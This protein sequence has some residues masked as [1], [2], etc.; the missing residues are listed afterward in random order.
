MPI[1]VCL[2]ILDFVNENAQIIFLYTSYKPTK[3][4]MCKRT[5]VLIILIVNTKLKNP[6]LSSV[7]VGFAANVNKFVK[8]IPNDIFSPDTFEDSRVG[9]WVS[10]A[11]EAGVGGWGSGCRGL[12]EAGVWGWGSGCLGMGKRVSGDGEAGVWGWGS[13]CL[14][15]GKRVSGDGEGRMW[16]CPF[17]RYNICSTVKIHFKWKVQHWYFKLSM[18]IQPS[19]NQPLWCNITLNWSTG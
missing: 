2:H 9:K 8:H 15:M 12:G 6:H 19:T 18:F 13:G 7:R 5:L 10:G 16:D 14:G 4:H 11:G 3:S 1:K 17:W